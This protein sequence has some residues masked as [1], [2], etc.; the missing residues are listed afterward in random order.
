MSPSD[1]PPRQREMTELVAHGN[2]NREIARR[3]GLNLQTVKNHLKIIF[4]RTGMNS[5][6]ELALWYWG[7]I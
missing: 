7:K 3:M 4:D 2:Q 6:L 5:R 1:L